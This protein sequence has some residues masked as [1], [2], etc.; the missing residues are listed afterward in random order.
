MIEKKSFDN[1]L[2]NDV[3]NAF[4]K[5]EQLIEQN[6][7]CSYPQY[8]VLTE[9]EFLCDIGL[10]GNDSLEIKTSLDEI[11]FMAVGDSTLLIV[12]YDKLTGK[13]SIKFV[14][15]T[16]FPSKKNYALLKNA[17]WRAYG[18]VLEGELSYTDINHATKGD[19]SYCVELVPIGNNFDASSR[20]DKHWAFLL[21]GQNKFHFVFENKDLETLNIGEYRFQ[22]KSSELERGADRISRIIEKENTKAFSI[23]ELRNPLTEQIEK[24]VIGKKEINL[25]TTKTGEINLRV[26]HQ[27][28]R[29]SKK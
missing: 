14:T 27:E 29:A 10:E 26:A 4:E 15:L 3:R 16:I 25:F 21:P 19:F 8:V 22:I 2:E 13:R 18:F 28:E 6:R 11:N 9:E 20:I 5:A 12:L 24:Q 1:K 23:Q 7:R 17:Y